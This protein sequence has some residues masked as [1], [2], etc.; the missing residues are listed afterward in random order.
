MYTIYPRG[1][2]LGK[3][4]LNIF[5]QVYSCG[6]NTHRV[7][8]VSPPPS[9]ILVPTQLK[10]FSGD[11]THVCA[12]RYHSMAWGPKCL[13]TWGLNAG[14]L[15]HKMRTD[16][17]YVTKPKAVKLLNFAETEIVSA[18]S[19]DGA[20]SV[21]TKKGDIY[22][23]H[24]YQCRKIASRQLNVIQV[25]IFGGNLN[26]NLSGE[27]NKELKV[28][29]LTNTGNLLI[30]QESIPQ[31][32]RCIF[33]LNRPIII[34]QV[35][36]NNNGLLFVTKHGE[37]FQAV[38][39]PRKKKPVLPTNEKSAFHKFLDREDCISLKISKFPRIHRAV[40]ITSDVKGHDFCVIQVPPYKRFDAPG[41]IESEMKHNF[42]VLL[43]ECHENDDVH[44]VV[45]QVD[46]RYFPAH[47]FIVASK[48]LHFEKILIDADKIIKLEGYNSLIFEQFLLFVYTGDCDLLKC[49]ECPEKFKKLCEKMKE[50]DEMENS[51]KI[52]GNL[53]AF[54]VYNNNNKLKTNQN[55]KQSKIKN[56]VRML[57]EMAKKFGCIDLCTILSNYEMQ[58]YIIKKKNQEKNLRK[59]LQFD[60][61]SLTEF[62]DVTIKCTDGKQIKAH[63]C[64]LAA[65]SDY[66][67]NLFS[68]RWHGVSTICVSQSECTIF[69]A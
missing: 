43:Q 16:D 56:P 45:F 58:K 65:Q 52:D 8:G 51:E 13:Y 38:I 33:T 24:E 1:Q 18:D 36:I 23:L 60:K 55:N 30:W 63:K 66:F 35:S 67:N 11:I 47:R 27:P 28:I 59:H 44:D 42:G 48:S 12:G 34:K 61:T 17:N 10:H 39:K 7:L 41:I 25:S 21:Y 68:T 22:V 5:F 54:Q 2:P 14:Q 53:S 46:H 32:S 62:C 15:G 4:P 64:I 3:N 40:F 6:L 20:V 9:Q 69:F 26:T 57:H 31:L 19:S 37:A 49:G 50:N 29:A